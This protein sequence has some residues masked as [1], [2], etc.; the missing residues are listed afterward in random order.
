MERRDK[1]EVGERNDSG[2]Q[3]VSAGISHNGA[4]AG[5]SLCIYGKQGRLATMN[6]P[7]LQGP[8]VQSEQEKTEDERACLHSLYE[9]RCP[10]SPVSH[11]LHLNK[12]RAAGENK[13]DVSYQGFE[14]AARITGPLCV[15][16][17]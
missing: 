13:R 3:I 17:Q 15:C 4:L 11:G 12:V 16:V 2:C 10:L 14:R 1:E 8:F 5:D 9:Y 7:I 6:L